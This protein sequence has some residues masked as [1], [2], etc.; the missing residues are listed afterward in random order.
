MRPAVLLPILLLPTCAGD[1]RDLCQRAVDHVSDCAGAAPLEASSCDP[2]RAEALLASTCEELGEVAGEA[3]A[4]GCGWNVGI[5]VEEP[6]A[7]VVLA[8]AY[9]E[10]EAW[11]VAA[12]L[13]RD[14]PVSVLRS[15]QIYYLVWGGACPMDEIDALILAIRLKEQGRAPSLLTVSQTVPG[16]EPCP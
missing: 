16:C 9:A 7:Y 11:R 5:S 15:G 14:L 4:D 8:H 3:K 2:E 13:R 1:D 12:E 6:K 10:D